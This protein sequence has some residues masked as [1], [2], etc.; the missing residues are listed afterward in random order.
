MQQDGTEVVV[1]EGRK[2]GAGERGVVVGGIEGEEGVV[3]GGV[4]G[5]GGVAV[6]GIESTCQSAIDH[7]IVQCQLHQQQE[8][9]TSCTSGTSASSRFTPR[10]ESFEQ[11]PLPRPDVCLLVSPKP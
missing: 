7:G 8:S 9:H 4:E 6:G 11:C 5:E 2:G 1:E 3:V 10:L